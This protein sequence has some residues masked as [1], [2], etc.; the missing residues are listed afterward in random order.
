MT[1][2]DLKLTPKTEKLLRICCKALADKKAKSLLVLDVEEI[3]TITDFIIIATGNSEAHLK[4]L[5]GELDKVL[6]ENEIL[7]L[8]SEF[9]PGSG[10]AVVDAFDVMLHLFL[11]EQRALYSLEDLWKDA[12]TVELNL[13]LDEAD[14]LAV[15]DQK[16]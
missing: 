5:R 8:G 15:T 1:S 9:E 13:L 11:P 3:S 10:W 16:M 14:L 6:K 4:G 2:S 7:L 12:K